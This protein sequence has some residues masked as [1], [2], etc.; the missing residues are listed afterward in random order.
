[1]GHSDVETT[2]KYAQVFNLDRLAF[3]ARWMGCEELHEVV[4]ADSYKTP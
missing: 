4:Y 3:T 1:M 2:M